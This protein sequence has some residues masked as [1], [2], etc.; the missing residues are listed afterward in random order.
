MNEE[1][2]TPKSTNKTSIYV[3]LLFLV[4]VLVGLTLPFHYVLNS[5]AMFPKEQLTFSNT[6]ITESDIESIIERYYNSANVFSQQAVANEPLVRKLI[7][8][9]IIKDDLIAEDAGI[10][11]ED[12]DNYTE[13]ESEAQ[14]SSL[15]SLSLYEGEYTFDVDF[16]G[17]DQL[18]KRAIDLIGR[19][20]YQV[21]TDKW[22]VTS[23][24][25]Y[26]DGLVIATAG[27][28]HNAYSTNFI[29]LCDLY[30]DVLQIGMKVDD[31]FETFSED[32]TTHNKVSE[33]RSNTEQSMED[34]LQELVEEAENREPEYLLDASELYGS[35]EMVND[36]G[37]QSL[38]NALYELE[39]GG[40]L[41][42]MDFVG[43]GVGKVYLNIFG[44]METQSFEYSQNGNTLIVKYLNSGE[45][46]KF[47]VYEVKGN[48]E[49]I[50]ARN[51]DNDGLVIFVKE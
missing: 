13:D 5:L 30:N 40:S 20:K 46:V 37:D 6:F 14:I 35:Y 45:E 8:R 11:I 24:I 27:E 25:I 29:I 15:T 43:H 48:H 1:T 19:S 51:V 9:R 36:D 4:L 28:E 2:S 31:V 21:I 42:T 18:M 16:L 3:K 44:F 50:R 41:A 32:G 17:N 26:E 47:N 12:E 49:Y 38:D 10:L 34:L 22:N 33:W 23:P 7:E 39:F